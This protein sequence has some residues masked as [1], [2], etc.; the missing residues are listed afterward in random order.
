MPF[1]ELGDMDREEMIP[2]YL[3]EFLHV[4]NMTVASWSAKADSPFPEHTHPHE[5]ISIVWK[6]EFELTLD[7]E[8]Q[9]LRPGVIA[10]IPADAPHSGR[11]LTDCE[12]VDVFSPV[13]EDYQ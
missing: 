2:G 10:V 3:G 1:V 13:R 9:V 6:G 4:E 8:T 11:A 5:Q 12:I 7:G